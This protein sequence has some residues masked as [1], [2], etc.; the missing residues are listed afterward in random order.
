MIG[1]GVKAIIGVTQLR[2]N[3]GGIMMKLWGQRNACTNESSWISKYVREIDLRKIKEVLRER[4]AKIRSTHLKPNH[5]RGKKMRNWVE[6]WI[7]RKVKVRI[8][9]IERIR[10]WN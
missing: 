2:R 8:R 4:K 3:A 5:W 9:A 7:N 6:E 1:K 10:T